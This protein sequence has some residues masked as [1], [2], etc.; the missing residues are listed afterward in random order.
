MPQSINISNHETGDMGYLREPQVLALFPFSRSQLWALV[1]RGE[2][3][4]PVKLS[5][6]CSAWALRDLKA[7]A[8]KLR[9]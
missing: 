2:F 6:R 9:S 4:A 5:E 7:H 8:E 3:P 1:K